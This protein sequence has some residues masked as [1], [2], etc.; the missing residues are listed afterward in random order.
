MTD[1]YNS[2]S[3]YSATHRH[4]WHWVLTKLNSHYQGGGEHTKLQ[5]KLS[6]KENGKRSGKWECCKRV[7]FVQLHPSQQ[8][9]Y[10]VLNDKGCLLL[11]MWNI[12]DT[13]VF[14]FA[15]SLQF[16]TL[17]TKIYN[18]VTWS[19]ITNIWVTFYEFSFWLT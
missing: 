15:S 10:K 7:T 6:Q 11:W 16:R 2:R 3:N 12:V 18:N 14:L 5:S 8:Y 9:Y 13:A 4:L 19:D 17:Y 1:N